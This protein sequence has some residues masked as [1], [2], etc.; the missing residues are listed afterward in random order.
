MEIVSETEAETSKTEE[1]SFFVQVYSS[2]HQQVFVCNPYS[3]PVGKII[4]CHFCKSVLTRQYLKEIG[5]VIEH[6]N[7]SE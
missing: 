3:S 6:I 1:N 5:E 4:L 7:D 2:K